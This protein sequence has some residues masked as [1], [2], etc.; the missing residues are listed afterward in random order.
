MGFDVSFCLNS[1]MKNIR[2]VE[3]SNK[4][5]EF[6]KRRKFSLAFYSLVNLYREDWTVVVGR[7]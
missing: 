6:G 4:N 3:D 1:N 5:L 2:G 7:A